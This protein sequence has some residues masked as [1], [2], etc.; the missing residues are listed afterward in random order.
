MLEVSKYWCLCL[1]HNN[2]HYTLF[3][4]TGAESFKG[5]PKTSDFVYRMYVKSLVCNTVN[6]VLLTVFIN[7]QFFNLGFVPVNEKTF[8]F[9]V[10]S[11]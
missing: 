2:F 1:Q 9:C 8:H 11:V 4:D 6:Y 10:L 5:E 7:M 3:L